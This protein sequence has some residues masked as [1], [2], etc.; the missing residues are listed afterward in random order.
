MAKFPSA[1][2][3]KGNTLLLFT[4]GNLHGS[5]EEDQTSDCARSTV[6]FTV[7]ISWQIMTVQHFFR[8]SPTLCRS[9]LDKNLLLLVS[10]ELIETDK[11]IFSFKEAQ[12]LRGKVK[13]AGLDTPPRER[14]YFSQCILVLSFVKSSHFSG[15][16]LTNFSAY[17]AVLLAQWRV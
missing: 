17:R 1:S 12:L 8:R 6:Y 14:N 4:L 7:V 3:T 9:A 13:V 15:Q 5:L 11:A 16:Y 10:A 2:H